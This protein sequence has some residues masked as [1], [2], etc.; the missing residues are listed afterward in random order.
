MQKR[1]LML[2]RGPSMLVYFDWF[3]IGSITASGVT[4]A[5]LLTTI[6]WAASNFSADAETP[7]V[8]RTLN[9]VIYGD[10]EQWEMSL[11]RESRDVSSF[12]RRI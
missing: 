2:S 5:S 12:C 8:E 1:I 7:I 10:V 6:R 4:S 9:P 11:Y 3:K